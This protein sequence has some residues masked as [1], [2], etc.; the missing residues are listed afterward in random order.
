M[1][2]RPHLWSLRSRTRSLLRTMDNRLKPL[3]CPW[4]QRANGA[5]LAV[6]IDAWVGLFAQLTW[7]VYLLQYCEERGMV[8]RIRLTGPLY[9]RAPGLDWLGDLFALRH[10]REDNPG[11]PI[12]VLRISRISEFAQLGL[13]RDIPARISVQQA[14]RLIREQLRV[15]PDIQAHVDRF[16]AQHFDRR[17]VIGLHFRG[18]DK[19]TEAHRVSWEDCAATVDNYRRAHPDTQA[20]FVSSDEAAFIDWIR[21]RIAGI[22]VIAHDDQERSRDGKPIHTQAARGDNGQKAREALINTLLLSRCDVLIRSSSFMSAWSSLFRPDLPIIMLNAPFDAKCWFPDAE[23]MTRS[24][25]Q[26]L[27][28]ALRDVSAPVP[29]S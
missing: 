29:H 9:A 20:L 23:L 27:P 15:R 25:K 11:P 28:E 16:A 7:V 4:Q 21:G 6:D 19:V 14:A 1:S 18:T 3:Y 13:A 8:P 26:Y 2:V 5:V 17:R 12:G 24:M 22:E 10:R